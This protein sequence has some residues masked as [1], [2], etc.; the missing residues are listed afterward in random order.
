VVAEA[1][2]RFRE[3][4]ILA[5]HTEPAV[6]HES[7]TKEVMAH[8]AVEAARP[9]LSGGGVREVQPSA[10]LRSVLV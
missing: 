9:L 3:V 6:E 4:R 2:A 8:R 10:P 7:R 1:P 5:A